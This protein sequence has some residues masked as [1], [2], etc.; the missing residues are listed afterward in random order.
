M[1]RIEEIDWTIRGPADGG[2]NYIKVGPGLVTSKGVMGRLYFSSLL[3]LENEIGT[4]VERALEELEVRKEGV[5]GVIPFYH[6]ANSFRNDH[7][8]LLASI[9]AAY[10]DSAGHKV[11]FV[12][13]SSRAGETE[14]QGEALVNGGKCLL[15][16]SNLL[17]GDSRDPA[18]IDRIRSYGAE[19][20]AVCTP[21]D[22]RRKQG[23]IAGVPVVSLVNLSEY[24]FDENDP[25]VK[26]KE[27]VDGL[28]V[29]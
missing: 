22:R 25:A 20:L 29:I 28:N 15:F 1:A 12:D 7:S 16:T 8:K 23:S 24:T 6:K 11:D 14:Q 3:W 10:F 2:Y 5:E 26:G 17:P 27:V 9:A 21:V 19:P 13:F 18:L 4:L